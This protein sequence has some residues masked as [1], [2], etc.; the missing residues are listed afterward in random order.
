[1]LF[2]QIDDELQTEG[3]REAFVCCSL[4]KESKPGGRTGEQ[5]TRGETQV[6]KLGHQSFDKNRQL[7]I[8]H[9]FWITKYLTS[10]SR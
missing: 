4:T 5:F 9:R 3:S 7:A 6:R 2:T 8:Y 10:V 1:M